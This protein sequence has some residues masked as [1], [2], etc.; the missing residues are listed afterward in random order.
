MSLFDKLKQKL[1]FAPTT[2][3]ESQYT[4][5]Y[6]NTLTMGQE[7]QLAN[8]MINYFS[9]EC[10]PNS[11]SVSPQGVTVKMENA[12]LTGEQLKKI[13]D[14]TLATQFPKAEVNSI[15]LDGNVIW[16]RP[17]LANWPNL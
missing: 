11:I 1:G 10:K 2:P 4:I 9:M 16:T 5:K 13:S 8:H 17:S 7:A 15:E 14:D 6:I 3:Q 12:C